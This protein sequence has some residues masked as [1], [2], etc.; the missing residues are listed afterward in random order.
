M[1]IVRSKM[2]FE[3][4]FTVVPNA[5]ARDERLSLKARGLLA[6]LMSHA[7]GWESSVDSLTGDRD[8]PSAVKSGL[9]ELENA[10]YLR[11]V[12]VNAEAGK[13]SWRAELFD[14]HVSDQ[15]SVEN[16]PVDNRDP[17]NTTSKKTNTPSSPPDKAADGFEEW[18]AKY[19]RKAS[20]GA[21]RR[22]FN[23][24]LKRTDLATLMAGL[25]AYNAV[26]RES[27]TERE[28]IKMPSTWL[29]GECW[30]DDYGPAGAASGGFDQW[31]N[32]VAVRGDVAVVE[33]TLGLSYPM[34]EVPLGVVRGA[35]LEASRREWLDSV[36][37]TARE[38][39]MVQFGEG[40][41]AP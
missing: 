28:F 38:R 21:A 34:P 20:K 1:T 12:R 13:F 26:L 30:A 18:Y 11:R 15:P 24:A 7:E 19:P 25:D 17:K 9:R 27:G 39:F 41:N 16:R 14:P 32:D 40:R 4:D 35:F 8:G 22:A 36:R 3:K 23:T 31:W 6:L 37:E 29:N 33:R 10:G 2:R 5:W